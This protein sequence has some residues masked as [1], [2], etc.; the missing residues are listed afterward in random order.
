MHPPGYPLPHVPL[1]PFAGGPH[2]Q[3]Y[4]IPTRGA[5]HGPSGAVPPVPQPGNRGFGAGRGNAGGPIGGHLAHQQ[6]SQ[7]TL[8][9]GSA[10]N[11]P[12]LDDSNSQP[13]VG[14]P[15]S[16]TGLMTQV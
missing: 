15:S 4:A 6:N 7:Q 5:V 14:A 1:S 12:P 10:F 3:P 11:F 8:G 2:S 16:Q 9:I 13:S